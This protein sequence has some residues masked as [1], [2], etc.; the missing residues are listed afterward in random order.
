[1]HD[2]AHACPALYFAD[3]DGII[4][5][6]HFGEGRYEQSERLIQKLLGVER[7]LVSVEGLGVE[8]AAD[9]DRLDTPE[10]YLAM[11]AAISC[12]HPSA[13]GSTVTAPTSSRS[14]CASTDGPSPADGRSRLRASCLNRPAE[15]CVPVR[16][17]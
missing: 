12:R 6:K 15:A 2:P 8:A 10:T 13:P 3:A 11:R 4:R 7:E 1:V 16:R 5:D 17:A 9:W 14:G